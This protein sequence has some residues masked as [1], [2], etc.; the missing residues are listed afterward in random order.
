LALPGCSS[1]ARPQAAPRPTS[2]TTTAAPPTSTTTTSTTAPPPPAAGPPVA[3][4]DPAGLAQQITDAERAVRDP[5]TPADVAARAGHAAQV[6]YRAIVNHPEW[7]P[8]VQAHVPGDIQP[9]VAANVHAGW[10]LRS[11]VTK[12]KDTLPD[13]RIVAPE[14]VEELIAHYKAAEAE[15]GVPWQYLAAVNLVETRM[16][17]IRGLSSAGAAGPMQFMPS[18]WAAYGG[19][20][21][22]NSYQDAIRAAARYLKA[23]G[24]PGD[25]RNALWNYN[26]S[27][28]YVDAVTQYA[29]Q[30]QA[31]PRAVY[32]YYGWQVYYLTSSGDVL[33]PEG[34][35]RQ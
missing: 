21:D 14:P 33:L 1:D 17:R 10:I 27:F 3:A 8:L 23:N 11:M 6:A 16:G 25:M 5:A 34:W 30:M 24:A 26:H 7:L 12:P 35:A 28:K 22:I 4:A 18:T 29:Q 9:A 32:G 2:T 15:F 20:G 13:W 19:G 31:Q